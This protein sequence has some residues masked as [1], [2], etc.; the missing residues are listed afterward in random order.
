MPNKRHKT[1]LN[2]NASNIDSPDWIK[3]ATTNPIIDD[4]KLFQYVATLALNQNKIRKNS[5][6]I[7]KIKLFNK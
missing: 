4:E 6:V 7:E 5:Q 2:C 3:K 1:N